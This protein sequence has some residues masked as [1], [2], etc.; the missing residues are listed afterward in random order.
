LLGQHT[1]E[2]LT[3]AGYSEEEIAN[4]VES[5]AAVTNDI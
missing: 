3:G 4:L 5:G 2:V 1:R